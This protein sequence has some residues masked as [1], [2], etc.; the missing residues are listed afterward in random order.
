MIL[1]TLLNFN[2]GMDEL[3]WYYWSVLVTILLVLIF[4]KKR[5]EFSFRKCLWNLLPGRCDCPTDCP[6]DCPEDKK[7]FEPV[8][9]SGV[10]FGTWVQ[11]PNRRWRIIEQLKDFDTTG[12]ITKSDTAKTEKVYFSDGVVTK[13]TSPNVPQEWK[14]TEKRRISSKKVLSTFV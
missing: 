8:N 12:S 7:P 10:P 3:D 14:M 6:G 13:Q 1:E 2:L 9:L 5:Y 11:E 4:L